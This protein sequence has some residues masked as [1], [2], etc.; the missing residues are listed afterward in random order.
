MMRDL[1]GGQIFMAHD[2]EQFKAKG[3]R[4]YK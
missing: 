1:E 3:D 2:G 4:W